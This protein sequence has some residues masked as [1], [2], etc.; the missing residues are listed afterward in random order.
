M[1]LETSWLWEIFHPRNAIRIQ[2][3]YFIDHTT[4]IESYTS[5][6]KE[7]FDNTNTSDQSEITDRIGSLIGKERIWFWTERNQA[8]DVDGT[9]GLGVF[10][11]T[12]DMMGDFLP[13]EGASY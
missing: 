3:N 13:Q 2:Y 12:I 9:A 6:E 8:R 1:I 10:F 5:S 7:I 11:Y 4:H